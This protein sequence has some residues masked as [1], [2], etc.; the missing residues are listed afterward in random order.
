MK[1][2]KIEELKGIFAE[3]ITVTSYIGLTLITAAIIM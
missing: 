2:D 1:H 3:L